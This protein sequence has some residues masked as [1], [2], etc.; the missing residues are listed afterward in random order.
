MAV[1]KSW[2]SIVMLLPLTACQAK[3]DYAYLMQHPLELRKAVQ[4]CETV[5][6]EDAS[7]CHE[8][9]RAAT[10]FMSIARDQQMDPEKFGRRVM[11]A[12]D[13]LVK[14]KQT[15][16]HLQTTQAPADQITSATKVYQ[17]KKEE[18]KTLLAV[19]ST[20]SPE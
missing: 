4:R 17:A 2:A 12:E 11:Q 14:A 20:Q 1:K 10:D 9:Q 8:V 19:L 15:L 13:Q 16:E 5:A 3:T 18:V 7:Q 6:S